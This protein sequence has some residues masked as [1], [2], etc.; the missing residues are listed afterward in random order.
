MFKRIIVPLDGSDLAE[1]AIRP[2]LELAR[3]SGGEIILISVPVYRP[4][5]VPGAM[6]YGVPQTESTL[7]VGREEVEQY[8][9]QVR[10]KHLQADVK[11]RTMVLSGDAAG[12]IVDSAEEEEAD[13]IAMTTHGYSGLTRWMLGSVTERVLRA[14][15][16][17][18]LV[19]RHDTPIN[20][21]LITLDGSRWAEEALEPAL[22]VARCFKSK[23]TLLRADTEEQ[24][25]ALEMG[26]LRMAGSALARG[27]A[28][29]DKCFACDYV[30]QIAEQ[31]QQ[32]GEEIAAI[33]PL[34]KPAEV[35]LET[36]EKEG[37][38]L[39]AIATHG[40]SGLE[41]WVFGSVT[42]KVLR[43]ADCAMLIVRPQSKR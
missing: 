8:L 13:L 12:A 2:A 22:H 21:V 10:R 20:H 23:V 42:E 29:D 16:C 19:M 28:Q 37:V 35:I 39:I 4:V 34:G 32:P 5:V 1:I 30:E 31:Y 11:M 27:V 6:G 38:D 25:N 7:E 33:A 17:P 40:Y 9:A 18:V 3:I 24:L 26:L 43:K 36:I 14:A 15:P 41:R